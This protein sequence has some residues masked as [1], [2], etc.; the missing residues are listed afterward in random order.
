MDEILLWEKINLAICC[1]LAHERA[2]S[3]Q[4]SDRYRL[5][6]IYA[7]IPTNFN[8]LLYSDHYY[9]SFL[10]HLLSDLRCVRC[11]WITISLE[12]ESEHLNYFRFVCALCAHGL[13][14]SRSILIRLPECFFDWGCS[15]IAL[16]MLPVDWFLFYTVTASANVCVDYPSSP[17]ELVVC[18]AWNCGQCVL[19]FLQFNTSIC[20]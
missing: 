11:R 2:R 15:L 6:K 9:H 4:F 3:I 18:V 12:T 1:R 14:H 19:C 17:W 20:I 8:S 10:Q 5:K 16:R 7:F 13:L